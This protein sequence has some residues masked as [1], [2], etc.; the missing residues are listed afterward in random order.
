MD[1]A[2]NVSEMEPTMGCF[3]GRVHHYPLRVFYE[4]TDYVDNRI[5][6]ILALI[7]L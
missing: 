6:P 3:K 1:K 7:S 4:D 5:M 2:E